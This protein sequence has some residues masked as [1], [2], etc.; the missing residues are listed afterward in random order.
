MVRRLVSDP[1]Q[2]D[3]DAIEKKRQ[4]LASLL[5]QLKNLQASAAVTDITLSQVQL[6]QDEESETTFDDTDPDS[7]AAS[8][9]GTGTG[10]GTGSIPF[11]NPNPTIIPVERQILTLPS[12]HHFSEDLANVE[13]TLRTKQAKNQLT[14]VRDIIAEISF[15]YS[16]VIQGNNNKGVQ[17][18]SRKE[19]KSLR[20]TLVLHARIYSRCRNKLAALHCN[21]SLLRRFRLLTKDDIKASTAIINPNQLGSTRVKLSWIWHTGRW[22]LFNNPEPENEP[23]PDAEIDADPASLLECSL[24]F[25]LKFFSYYI[26]C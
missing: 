23:D 12:T 24:F 8:D 25:Y 7:E 6:V 2:E 5:I 9:P 10:T 22:Y 18:R 19:I 16:H 21:P 20:N 14:R 13:I 26:N 17:T 11:P 1:R 15:R 3:N 4:A